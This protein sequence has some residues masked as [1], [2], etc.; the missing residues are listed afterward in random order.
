MGDTQPCRGQERRLSCILQPSSPALQLELSQ[1]KL[2]AQSLGCFFGVGGAEGRNGDRLEGTTDRGVP[3]A[4]SRSLAAV[5]E[6]QTL[7]STLRGRM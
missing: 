6:A 5:T 2:G 1:K 3:G 7:L 4:P